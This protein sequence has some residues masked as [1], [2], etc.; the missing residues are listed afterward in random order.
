MRNIQ[1]YFGPSTDGIIGPNT[2]FV[3]G[4]GVGPNTTYGSRALS[5]GASGGDVTILQNRLNC[6]R[7]A[8]LIGRPADGDFDAA[9]SQA[10]SPSR[11]MQPATATR[12]SR[13]TRP[14]ATG[15]TTRVGSRRS[16]AVARFSRD[17]TASTSCSCRPSCGGSGTTADACT[18]TTTQP[19]ARP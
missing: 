17:E 9:T 13:P 18:D 1:S 8:S 2:Y 7:Y 4:K 15:R 16:R 10:V 6:F 5:Q 19:P 14:W 11:G 12:A 3:Y